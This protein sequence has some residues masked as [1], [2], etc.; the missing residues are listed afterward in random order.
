M[1]LNNFSLDLDSVLYQSYIFFTVDLRFS[2]NVPHVHFYWLIPR[3]SDLFL[4][5]NNLRIDLLNCCANTVQSQS[6][7]TE[8]PPI[9][10]WSLFAKIWAL[11]IRV[12]LVRK[13]E[14][15]VVFAI[16]RY[17]AH[18]LIGIISNTNIK[19]EFKK[20]KGLIILLMRT[21]HFECAEIL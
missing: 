21:L 6:L 15:E 1:Q 10:V 14:Q 11:I 17:G 7:S 20:T 4:V 9:C 5:P 19:A 8:I 3:R 16:G 13:G 2:L 18:S 12:I